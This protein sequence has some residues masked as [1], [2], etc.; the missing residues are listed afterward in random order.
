MGFENAISLADGAVTTSKLANLSVTTEKLA[1]SNVTT[2]KI[3]DNNVTYTKLASLV[4]NMFPPVGSIMSWAKSITGV[5]ALPSGW[6]ECNGQ[7]L[8]DVDS[9]LNGQVIPNLNDG[10]FLYGASASGATKTENY[11]PG[12]TH[13]VPV[14]ASGGVA[15]QTNSASGANSNVATTS[16]T[17]GT[18][19]LGYAVVW[20]MRVK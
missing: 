20:I 11:L 8:S 15:L 9:P 2:V 1:D 17:S 10:D 6:V 4:Q 18:A 19:W 7:T 13:N 5:P 12:H 16:T 3:A 14:F